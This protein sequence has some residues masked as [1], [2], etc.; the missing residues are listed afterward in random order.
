MQPL[1][2]N[3]EDSEQRSGGRGQRS[4]VRD[5]VRDQNAAHGQYDK[6]NY[7]GR[8]RYYSLGVHPRETDKKT[9]LYPE[10]TASLHGPYRHTVNRLP[11]FPVSHL[12]NFYFY[13]PAC[14]GTVR[15]FFYTLKAHHERVYALAS[16]KMGV[17]FW[18]A[19]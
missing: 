7:P 14:S 11:K 16:P 18:H 1:S 15:L 13:E 9:T 5:Q 17:D 19:L 8:V 3:S 2:E 12:L 6:H 10:G 4:E